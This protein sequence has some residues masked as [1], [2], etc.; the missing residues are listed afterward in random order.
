MTS[1]YLEDKIVKDAGSDCLDD[2]FFELE[3]YLPHEMDREVAFLYYKG[4]YTY[5][6]I[7][8]LL[9]IPYNQVR[10]R[11]SRFINAIVNAMKEE[12]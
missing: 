6:E 12:A 11:Y 5:K 7:H 3:K 10:T 9:N 8:Q 4:G 1:S 2:I